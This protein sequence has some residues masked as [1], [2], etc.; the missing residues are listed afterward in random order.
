MSTASRE[1]GEI[2][3]QQEISDT[4]EWT[5]R[6]ILPVAPMDDS[7]D[8][9]AD[10]ETG[11]EY[12]RLVR[13]QY[14]QLPNIRLPCEPVPSTAVQILDQS[15]D[16][17]KSLLLGTARE[18]LP[19]EEW[20][21]AIVDTFRLGRVLQYERGNY[22]WPS[23]GDKEGWNR[24]LYD[25]QQPIEDGLTRISPDDL[26][27][28]P[29]EQR[30]ILQLVGFHIGWLESGITE[31]QYQWLIR[32]LQ[33]LDPRLTARQTSLL[34]E[35][36]LCCMKLRSVEEADQVHLF[37]LNSIISIVGIE[38]GQRDLLQI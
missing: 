7:F 6:A 18:N 38:F 30:Q 37:Y 1:E 21:M 31:R 34:R 24:L 15:G 26:L 19:S 36:A 27:Q 17:L 20:S 32:L 22:S 8:P 4:E 5:L 28:S 25:E 9:E 3:C 13:Y 23:F 16:T 35:L 11:E 29:P 12:L 2:A 33:C 14:E 10:P